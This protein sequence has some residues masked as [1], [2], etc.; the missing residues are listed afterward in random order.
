MYAVGISLGGLHAKLVHPVK[1]RKRFRRLHNYVNRTPSS[2]HRLTYNWPLIE[3]L[4]GR[5]RL[6][7][8]QWR[9]ETVQPQLHQL[10]ALRCSKLPVG[11]QLV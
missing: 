3:S 1:K 6:S 7:Y 5:G 8:R 4:N 11:E 10:K 2:S 9:I